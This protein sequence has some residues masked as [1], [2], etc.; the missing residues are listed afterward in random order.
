MSV[1]GVVMLLRKQRG[2]ARDRRGARDDRSR[3]RERAP[4]SDAVM[5]LSLLLVGATDC[6]GLY[7]ISHGQVSPGGGFQGGAALA[8][9]ALVVFLASDA[10][11]S[12]P[13]PRPGASSRAKRWARRASSRWVFSGS[14]PE[15]RS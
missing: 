4:A 11:R 3:T 6:F 5:A 8:T 15:G 1:L 10:I 13:S 12:G 9:A 7:L 14:S 2:E